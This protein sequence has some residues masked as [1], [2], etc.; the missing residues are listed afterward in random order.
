[1]NARRYGENITNGEAGVIIYSPSE[2]TA[3]PSMVYAS[4]S[5]VCLK[6]ESR[7]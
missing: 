1:M 6:E 2:E 4:A 3:A 7:R 5:P